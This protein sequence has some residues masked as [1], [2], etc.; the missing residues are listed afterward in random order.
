MVDI[1]DQWV[2]NRHPCQAKIKEA[3]MFK[4]SSFSDYHNSVIDL[5]PLGE[6]TITVRKWGTPKP[7]R[8]KYVDP[9]QTL[10]LGNFRGI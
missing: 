1:T 8:K 10:N 6:G 3:C 5:C 7:E 4:N 2:C 9:Q